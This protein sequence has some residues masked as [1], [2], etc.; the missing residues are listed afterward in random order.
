MYI[1]LLYT[2]M[3]IVFT[4]NSGLQ[5]TLSYLDLRKQNRKTLI[6]TNNLA[7]PHPIPS[8]E[9]SS[10]YSLS[11]HRTYMTIPLVSQLIR[12]PRSPKIFSSLGARFSRYE[13]NRQSLVSVVN[14]ADERGREPIRISGAKLC[15]ICHIF[16]R[17]PK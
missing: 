13:H 10:F 2:W 8:T 12:A 7:P 4:N 11:T 16:C 14:S 6:P 15:C 17:L 9:C 1:T 5:V 3:K